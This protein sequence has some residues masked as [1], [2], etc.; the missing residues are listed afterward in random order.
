MSGNKN[1]LLEQSSEVM[2]PKETWVQFS[3]G[4]ALAYTYIAIGSS[5]C[6]YSKL[7]IDKKPISVIILQSLDRNITNSCA[8]VT[9]SEIWK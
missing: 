5:Y 6:L 2:L 1:M 7:S 8:S 9:T 4:Q 3:F